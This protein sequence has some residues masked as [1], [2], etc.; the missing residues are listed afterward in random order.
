MKNDPVQF[1]QFNGD[2]TR[3][4]ASIFILLLYNT[5]LNED[6]VFYKD[7]PV[8]YAASVYSV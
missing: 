3:Q 7:V 1:I 5:P 4:A 2:E 8:F 6:G